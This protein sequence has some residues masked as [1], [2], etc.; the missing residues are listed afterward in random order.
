MSNTVATVIAYIKA[1]AALVGA[2]LTGVS[3]VLGSPPWVT[4]VLAICTGIATALVPWKPV[5]TPEGQ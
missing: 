5:P 4:W 1:I 2:V 3:G